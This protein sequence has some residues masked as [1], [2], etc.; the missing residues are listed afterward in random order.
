MTNIVGIDLGTT[1]SALSIL[2]GIGKPEIIPNADGERLTPSAIFFDE[3]NSDIVRVGIEAINSR[4]LNA[5]RSVRWIKRHMGDAKYQKEIDSKNWSP[6]ELS[7][8]ILKKLKQDCSVEHGDICDAVISVPAHFDEVR[9]TATMEAGK[10]AGLNVIGIVNEPVAAALYYATTRQVT[11]KV[12]VYD[13]GGGTFDVTIME[14]NGH[15]MKIVCSQGDHALG[16][17]DFD[18][19]ILEILEQKYKEKFNTDL[20]GS[21]EDRAKYE[22]EAE[23]IKRTLSRRNVAKKM[24]YGPAGNMRMEISRQMFEE[25]IS[26]LM[27]RADILVEV[28]LGEAGIEPA[29][30]DKVL[31]VGGSTRIPF[32]QQR[33]GKMFGKSPE[34]AVNVDECV[35]LGAA[36][37]AGLTMLREKPDAVS[38]G[39]SSSLMD[40]NLTD[41]CNHSYGTIC[42]PI[43]KET[44]RRVVQNRI[45]LNKN[46]SLPCETSQTFYTLRKGQAEVEV[47]ITQ[48]EGND[49]E[50]VNRIATYKFE[51][52]PDRPAECPI[53]VT[54]SYDVNQRMHCKF[55]DVE[56]GRV[57]EI[58]LCLDQ[59][60]KMSEN[61]KKDKKRQ[62]AAVG[63][64]KVE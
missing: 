31:L 53:K 8:L 33:L 45:I 62:L 13:L 21:D 16:G 6:V 56:S 15:D 32:V 24:L 3:E 9:R 10:I 42:A 43:D 29:G 49:A 12:L 34:T 44:G 2:N 52:P 20:I 23:D 55:E 36:M 47:T 5:E 19:K 37:Y 38:A 39:I 50:F 63:K 48:G 57:L 46:T 18:Q 60:G 61:D 7:A 1:F 59:D 28:A 41:V 35:G 25:A 54:Y 26:S 4:H 30:I 27:D 40:I 22:D 17:I 58:D 14:V 64:A 11:G 51:L